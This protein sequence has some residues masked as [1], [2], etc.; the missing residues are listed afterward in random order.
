MKDRH[1]ITRRHNLFIKLTK[2]LGFLYEV[3]SVMPYLGLYVHGSHLCVARYPKTESKDKDY[4]GNHQKKSRL[5]SQTA[6]I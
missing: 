2:T 4:S 5:F 3:P 6:A 1:V